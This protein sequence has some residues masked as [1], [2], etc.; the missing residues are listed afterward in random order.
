ML[1][2]TNVVLSSGEATP[3]FDFSK[4]FNLA[5]RLATGVIPDA[6]YPPK[7]N[8]FGFRNV[9]FR[10]AKDFVAL[11]ATR[12]GVTAELFNAFNFTNYGCLNSF[13]GDNNDRTTLGDP[14]CVVSLGRRAQAGLKV[15][16]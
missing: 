3:Y 9:D 6:V 14:N 7:E 10:L 11:G 16:F 2:S 12:I 15:S 1:F 13:V 8:G 4:G 5:G